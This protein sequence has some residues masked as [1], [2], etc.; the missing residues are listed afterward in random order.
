MG[1]RGQEYLDSANTQLYVRAQ[2]IP[3]NG[4]NITHNVASV[5]LWMHSLFLKVDV[6]FNDTLVTS[7]NNTYSYRAYLKT[8]LSFGPAA[9]K[10][11]LTAS[12][13]YKN[14]AGEMDCVDLQAVPVV[15]VG[16]KKHHDHT[17]TSTVFDMVGCIH[18]DLFFQDKC[19]PNDVSIRIRFV[20]QKYSFALMPASK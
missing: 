11:Q 7:T 15:N 14:T 8:L 1:G 20:H 2:T 5:N 13:Y 3:A 16:L 19:I 12:M 17:A 10:S 4:G 6:K 18:C 9:M